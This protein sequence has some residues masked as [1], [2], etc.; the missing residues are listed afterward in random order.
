MTPVEVD[1]EIAAL[2][3]QILDLRSQ[4]QA[5]GNMVRS[6]AGMRDYD[7]KTGRYINTGTWAEAKAEVARR[8]ELGEADAAANANRGESDR[9]TSTPDAISIY[10]AEQPLRFVAEAD[11]LIA[12]IDRL[13]TD[14]RAPL[15]HEYA[16]RPWSRFY[17]VT[18][19]A[20]H[21]HSSTNCQTCRWSTAFGWV[22]E[23]SGMTEAEAMD[24]LD[25]MSGASRE[26]LC[27]VCFPN[28][29]VA[30]K[31]AHITKAKAAALVASQVD[32]E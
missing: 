3:R 9:W 32:S 16:S 12:E 8:I 28:A 11:A 6:A 2:D 15:H 30:G 20:G 29:P 10:K 22:P 27:S 26:T 5:R 31:R 14:E 1:T 18:S 4:V 21:V 25:A 24:A 17:L 7:R 13:A 23:L 19:S